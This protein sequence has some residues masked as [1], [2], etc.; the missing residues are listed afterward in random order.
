MNYANNLIL[1][2]GEVSIKN[3]MR[4]AHAKAKAG[5][6]DRAT[7][8]LHFGTKRIYAEDFKEA[9]QFMWDRAHQM[10]RMA[11]AA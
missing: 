6:S 2:N 7:L 11:E 9:L 3:V 1:S 4:A 10:Q 5:A 8:Q